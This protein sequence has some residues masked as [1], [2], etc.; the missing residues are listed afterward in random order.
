MQDGPFNIP[1][2]PNSIDATNDLHHKRVRCRVLNDNSARATFVEVISGCRESGVDDE[3]INV[4]VRIVPE[5]DGT[6]SLSV[7][8]RCP[9][10]DDAD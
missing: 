3:T 10:R 8:M 6:L 1:R 2:A 4:A 5:I 9:K 7:G